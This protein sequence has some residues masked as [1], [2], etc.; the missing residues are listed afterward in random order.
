MNN[1]GKKNEQDVPSTILFRHA[2]LGKTTA[3]C[4]EDRDAF[5]NHI[6]LNFYANRYEILF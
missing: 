3:I 5:E 1:A 2:S 6:K 4:K